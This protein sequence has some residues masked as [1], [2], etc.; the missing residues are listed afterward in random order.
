VRLPYRAR[1][2]HRRAGIAKVVGEN[3][4]QTAEKRRRTKIGW[5]FNRDEHS[6]RP[7]SGGLTLHFK[8]SKLAVLAA[9]SLFKSRANKATKQVIARGQMTETDPRLKCP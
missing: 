5:S 8:T 1:G 2:L 6:R 4:C 9:V 3:G 7:A